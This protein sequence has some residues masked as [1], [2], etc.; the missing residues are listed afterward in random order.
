[1]AKQA[2]INGVI[3]SFPDD[4][5]DE[6]INQA[7]NGFASNDSSIPSVGQLGKPQNSLSSFFQGI[8]QG[9]PHALK[10]DINAIAQ[11]AGKKPFEESQLQSGPF[12]QRVGQGVGSLGGHLSAALPAIFGSEALIPG[13]AG[14]SIGA[15]L[16]GAATTPGNWKERLGHG[17][18]DAALPA[19]FKAVKEGGKLGLAAL[20]RT[21]T[22]R[23][24]ADVIQK[25]HETAYKFATSPLK[26]AEAEASTINK[27]I[28]LSSGILTKA[29]N[30][31]AN[32]QANKALI[33]KARS[34][35]Y[36]SV[37][38]LQSD[39]YKRGNA[40]TSKQTQAEIDRGHEILDLRDSLIKGMKIHYDYLGKNDVSKNL[41]EGQKRFKEFADLYHANPTV[42]K[43]VGKEKIVPK[44]LLSKLESDT[45]Y[46]NKLKTEIP[47]IGKMLELQKSKRNLKKY[48]KVGAGLGHAGALVKY[49]TGNDNHRSNE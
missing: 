5:T 28:R 20:K 7:L 49:L 32:T 15:G 18:L 29:E 47:E 13:L 12:S 48:A 10:G 41:S 21:P 35:D 8:G 9:Y 17:L 23:K 16:A 46:M 24:A 36:K 4:A 25:N 14:A 39:L 1:M 6:D 34:G 33:N 11:L 22:P 43:L 19:G 31:L 40:F 3:H 45:A 44:N 37:F 30:A 2:R 26:E 27:P 38:K 42:S